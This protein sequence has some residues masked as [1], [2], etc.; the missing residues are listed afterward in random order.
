MFAQDEI[1]LSPERMN[2]TLGA[3]FEH[4][5]Y[6]GFEFQP[7][8]RLAWLPD[9]QQTIWAALSR[10]VRAP[11]RIDGELVAPRDPPFTQLQGNPNFVSEE[12]IAYEL[13]YRVQPRAEISLAL[14]L[15]YHDYDRLRTSERVNPAAPMPFYLGNGQEGTASGGELTADY[16]ATSTWRLRAGY[17]HLHLHLRNKP[18]STAPA[19]TYTD[20]EHQFF[21]RST[22]DLPGQVEWDAT[23]RHVSRLISQ[24][25]PAYSELDMRLAWNP[26]PRWEWS[27]VGQNLLHDHHGEFNSSTS[28]QEIARSV[29]GKVTWRY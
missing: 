25:V 6:T 22:L 20:P 15:F 16:R 10:A 14:A 23:Y 24:N 17:T 2:L 9:K 19:P 27:V 21:L 29:Y 26:T 3:K 18:G 1:S 8:A 28:R 12:L 5:Y 11:S 4:N 7:S 13:G